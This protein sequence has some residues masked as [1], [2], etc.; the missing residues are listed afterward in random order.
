MK[1]LIFLAILAFFMAGCAKDTND[2]LTDTATPG[3]AAIDRAPTVP[4]NVT[5][6]TQPQTVLPLPPPILNLDIPGT[7]TGLHLGKCTWFSNSQVD[8]TTMPWWQTGDMIFTAADGST[9]IGHYWGPGMPNPELNRNDF[10][11]DYLITSGTKRFVG[12]TGSG[13]YYGFSGPAGSQV[14]FEGVLNRP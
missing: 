9:L 12:A 4:F 7:G 11:G 13:I 14:T 3:M 5:I 2:A 10:N 6:Q 1:N 8:I